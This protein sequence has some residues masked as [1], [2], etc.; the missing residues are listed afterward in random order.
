MVLEVRGKMMELV[1]TWALTF[2]SEPELGYMTEAYETLRAEGVRFPPAPPSLDRSYLETATAPPWTDSDACTRC[3][4][5][6]SITNRKHHCRNCGKTFCAA[7]STQS[8]PLPHYGMNNL[9]RVCDGC[10]SVRVGKLKEGIAKSSSKQST[11]VTDRE[12]DLAIQL[13]LQDYGGAILPSTL[14]AEEDPML[15]AAI[16]ASLD[17][18]RRRSSVEAAWKTTAKKEVKKERAKAY[19]SM[20][21]SSKSDT[22]LP[23]NSTSPLAQSGNGLESK[24]KENIHLFHRLVTKMNEK[25]ESVYYNAEI[26]R[27][28]SELLILSTKLQKLMT[29]ESLTKSNLEHSSKRISEGIKKY[30]AILDERL[31]KY[32][33]SMTL[34]SSRSFS[35]DAVAKSSA[36][37]AASYP[38]MMAGSH[39]PPGMIRHPSVPFHH[40]SVYTASHAAP[41]GTWMPHPSSQLP[42]QLQP[43]AV[44]PAEEAKADATPVEDKPLIEF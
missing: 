15:A 37:A 5:P 42:H 3:Q 43:S 40:S 11:E 26:Q 21:S 19:S 33:S 32:S 9:E 30:D 14:P 38:M 41:P 22:L 13:S 10:Y 25:N 23:S 7:C 20:D 8:M 4:A 18:E 36:S 31:Q 2:K 16:A 1:Q 39:V 27:L 28:Y 35:G 6:F 29:E 24:E 17:E 44:K 12:L 34:N